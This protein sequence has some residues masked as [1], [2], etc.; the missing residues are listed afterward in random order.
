MREHEHDDATHCPMC[1][2]PNDAD[3]IRCRA[4]GWVLITDLAAAMRRLAAAT[5]E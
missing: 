5:A 2:F 1:D 4:C 3:A